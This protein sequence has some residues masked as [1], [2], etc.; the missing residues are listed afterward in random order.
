MVVLCSGSV[1]W[2]CSRRTL[3][4][5]TSC[6]RTAAHT[7][8]CHRRA[9]ASVHA[10]PLSDSRW[11]AY[12][13]VFDSVA[14]RW[15]QQVRSRSRKYRPSRQRPA[16]PRPG[17]SHSGRRCSRQNNKNMRS[18]NCGCETPTAH[19][20]IFACPHQPVGIVSHCVCLSH[21]VKFTHLQSLLVDLFFLSILLAF[22]GWSPPP[23]PLS[24]WV[25]SAANG[26]VST[27]RVVYRS[28]PIYLEWLLSFLPRIAGDGICSRRQS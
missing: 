15:A 14:F 11:D 13:S 24:T 5:Y 12:N 9:C 1:E 20:R 25:G 2:T 18:P 28:A 27:T 7:G 10:R 23:S 26:A 21:T 8:I 16:L 19:K 6:R 17:C 22:Q 4:S 3:R